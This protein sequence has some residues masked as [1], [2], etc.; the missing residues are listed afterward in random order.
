[1]GAAWLQMRP[2]IAAAILSG[3]PWER[4]RA[5]NEIRMWEATGHLS[6]GKLWTLLTDD[7]VKTCDCHLPTHEFVEVDGKWS[8]KKYRPFT[9]W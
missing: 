9:L 2:E 6:P 3:T 1:M 4:R 5:L 7:E 8:L